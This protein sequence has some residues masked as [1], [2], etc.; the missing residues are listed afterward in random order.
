L[1]EKKLMPGDMLTTA[2]EREAFYLSD[3]ANSVTVHKVRTR[4]QSKYTKNADGEF[5][6]EYWDEYNTA[7]RELL[8]GAVELNKP[9][10]G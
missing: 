4:I 3:V 8:E 2:D 10:K 9:Y 6:D 5:P 1:E 7:L